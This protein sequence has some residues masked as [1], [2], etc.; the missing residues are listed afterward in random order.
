MH[1]CRPDHALHVIAN[2]WKL[3]LCE[4]PL[5]FRVGSYENWNRVHE[6]AIG[7]ERYFSPE[8]RGLLASH[9]KVIHEYFGAA[10]LYL[11]NDLLLQFLY[12]PFL[13][14]LHHAYEVFAQPVVERALPHHDLA[15]W[16]PHPLHH[17]RFRVQRLVKGFAHLV[18]GDIE[19]A[20]YFYIAH[21]VAAY[22]LVHYAHDLALRVLPV[23]LYALYESRGAVPHAYYSDLD[24]PCHKHHVS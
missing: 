17:V 21:V 11:G 23:I 13:H 9:R 12:R 14:R 2:H 5:P 24:L 4:S 15:L 1:Y 22:V 10:I 19:R 16:N 6:R 20:G 8:L 7:L 3:R 18:V